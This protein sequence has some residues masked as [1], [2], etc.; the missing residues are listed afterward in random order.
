MPTIASK[1]QPNGNND[2]HDPSPLLACGNKI[3]RTA[4]RHLHASIHCRDLGAQGVGSLRVILGVDVQL[5]WRFGHG[6]DRLT[7]E[8]EHHLLNISLIAHHREAEASADLAA[9][10]VPECASHAQG[11]CRG[12]CGG[13]ILRHRRMRSD[14]ADQPGEKDDKNYLPEM[15]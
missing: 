15:I 11:I 8:Q 14:Q 9:R 7:I 5:K 10:A 2:L 1:D 3:E 12:G 13:G 6:A 4:L